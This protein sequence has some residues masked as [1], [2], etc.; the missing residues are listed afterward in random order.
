MSVGGSCAGSSSNG[1]VFWQ[2][3][4]L[5]PQQEYL[6]AVM[7]DRI[8]QSNTD[9]RMNFQ[10]R[11]KFPSEPVDS[12]ERDR[13]KSIQARQGS[14]GG[15]L[16][17]DEPIHPPRSNFQIFPEN[18]GTDTDIYIPFPGDYHLRLDNKV[19]PLYV[20]SPTG[21]RRSGQTLQFST[22]SPGSNLFSLLYPPALSESSSNGMNFQTFLQKL[23]SCTQQKL[24]QILNTLGSP[25]DLDGK[26]QLNIVVTNFQ[27]SI[28]A[29]TLGMFSAIDRFEKDGDEPLID[30]NYGEYVYLAPSSN[31]S[32]SCATMIH[33]TQH[34][35]S[36]DR[37]VLAEIPASKRNDMRQKSKYDLLPEELGL[38]EGYSHIFEELSGE[39]QRVSEHIY[40]FFIRS[41]L[42]SFSLETSFSDYIGNSRSRGLNT[43]FLYYVI[44][45]AGGRLDY[46]DSVTIQT[47]TQLITNPKIGFP[48][49]ADHFG[50]T[51]QELMEGFFRGLL[52]SLF[53]S[54]AA[55]NFLPA[56]ET[57]TNIDGQQV[58]R[59]FKILDRNSST[60]DLPYAPPSVHPFQFTLNPLGPSDNF[61]VPAQGLVFYRYIVPSTI[62]SDAEVEFNMGGREISAYVVRV[63]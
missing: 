9:I 41:N 61:S 35:I 45:R 27:G 43:L 17:F 58:S 6:I 55:A 57:S 42:S 54:S 22:Y 1:A 63:R 31:P 29:R 8:P 3:K 32:T 10:M 15:D 23:N 13:I 48:N 40:N 21:T 4:D 18:I 44:K 60:E 28:G 26:P 50:V 16:S 34:Q 52:Y 5:K 62:S 46:S 2:L 39:S 51:E 56:L 30:S 11:N 12:Y 38:D 7:A 37:K 53:D 25:F 59:G 36:Y 47:L 20:S 24:P 49:I 14:G 33:E 19:L